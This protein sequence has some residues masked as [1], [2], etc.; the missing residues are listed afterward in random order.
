MISSNSH[1]SR[2]W[3]NK[4]LTVA[5]S[6]TH[7]P[8]KKQH[9][10]PHRVHTSLYRGAGVSLLL[11]GE[12]THTQGKFVYDLTCS[13]MFCPPPFL[14]FEVLHKSIPCS[15]SS[16]ICLL[17]KTFFGSLDAKMLWNVWEAHNWH[18]GHLCGRWDN[19]VWTIHDLKKLYLSSYIFLW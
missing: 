14:Q 7:R 4:T 1:S 6:C 10:G 8:Q 15:I 9:S 12:N 11:S 19:C 17:M 16:A 18:L 5:H 13:V 3:C 2:P